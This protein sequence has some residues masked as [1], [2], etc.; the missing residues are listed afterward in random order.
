MKRL[1]TLA[2]ALM[3]ALT[4]MIGSAAADKIIPAKV[5]MLA[6]L[7]TSENE[8]VAYH[9]A[10]SIA[11]Q[12]LIRHGQIKGVFAFENEPIVFDYGVVFYDELN[13]MLMGL[14]VGD[15]S[16]MAEILDEL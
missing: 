3:L 6:L 4:M 7:N 8:A 15:I 9:E 16:G 5:G 12:E 1:F 11:M 13:E 10:T 2:T 14:K